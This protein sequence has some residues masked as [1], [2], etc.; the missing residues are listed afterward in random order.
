MAS[1]FLFS[2]S[3]Y[4]HCVLSQL[5]LLFLF[6]L[7]SFVGPVSAVTICAR[8][9]RRNMWWVPFPISPPVHNFTDMHT[10][11]HARTHSRWHGVLKGLFS[12]LK[13]GKK[14]KNCLHTNIIHRNRVH[15]AYLFT[16][17][18]R[19]NATAV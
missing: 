1:F 2:I 3:M 4:T 5:C 8:K 13:E 9:M 15:T 10:R 18:I 14:V 17:C 6:V 7:F 11:T 19:Y 12:F 16:S